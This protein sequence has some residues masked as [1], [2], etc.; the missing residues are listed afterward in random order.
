MAHI[1]NEA[2]I[3]ADYQEGTSLSDLGVRYG[4]SVGTVRNTLIRLGVSRRDSGR[5]AKP[6]PTKKPCSS[7]NRTLLLK[8]FYNEGRRTSRCKKCE[9]AI[10][11]VKYATDPSFRDA[12]IRRSCAHQATIRDKRRHT[13]RKYQTGWTEAQFEAAWEAQEGRCAICRTS[14]EK[15]G[16]KA[17]SVCADHNH[18]TGQTRALLCR[19]CNLHLGI[20]ERNQERFQAYLEKWGPLG[21]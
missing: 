13:M 4:C 20:Y 12:S 21:A 10:A 7:C 1:L 9:R 16:H 3:A 2:Q 19:Q 18:S 6:V 11:R 5:V 8:N 14:M 17:N 15:T